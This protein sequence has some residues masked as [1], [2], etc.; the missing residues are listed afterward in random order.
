V[1]ALLLCACAPLDL[2]QAED[3]GEY[4]LKA[5]FLF[6]FA[7]FIDWPHGKFFYSSIAIRHMHPRN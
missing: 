5:A 3:A 7:K 1:A 4:Q 6:N 2:A